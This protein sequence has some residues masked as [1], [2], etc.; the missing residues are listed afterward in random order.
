MTIVEFF[1]VCPC[2]N[3]I[4]TT[5]FAPERVIFLGSEKTVTRFSPLYEAY[6]RKYYPQVTV[7]FRAVDT[8]DLSAILA[9]LC[10]IITEFPDAEFD[11]TGGDDLVLIAMGMLRERY[12]DRDFG[13]HRFNITGGTAH[14]P[15]KNQALALPQPPSITVEQAVTLCGGIV[16]ST[17]DGAPLQKQDLTGAFGKTVDRMWSISR[18]DPHRWNK[19][20]TGLNRLEKLAPAKESPLHTVIPRRLL[21][22]DTTQFEPT[23]DILAK[24]D[25][26]GVLTYREHADT[27]EI[28]Y[29]D[30]QVKR[31]LAKAGNVLEYK[32]LRL[33]QCAVDAGGAPFFTDARC[34]VYID[35]DGRFGINN[36]TN[37]RDTINEIDVVAT[38][39]V[40]PWFIS[41]KNGTVDDEEL[42]KFTVVARRFGG[43]YAKAVLVATYIDRNP[44]VRARLLQRAADMHI[45]L[46][47]R[48][49]ERTDEEWTQ[50][51]CSLAK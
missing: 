41:C 1:E 10:A 12:H 34:G 37:A 23:R 35:W 22:Q 50:A 45:V 39:G 13:M 5:A 21:S 16:S 42:Y 27:L 25:R 38:R 26:S 6:Y 43:R 19:A 51:L 29:P 17:M 11:V 24:L 4:S 33:V 14:D 32:T 48:V 3:I 36:A 18:E 47:D 49:H 9:A 44:A 28:T 31:A 46:V 30:A 20:I 7:L 2:H 8:T 15:L 40:V